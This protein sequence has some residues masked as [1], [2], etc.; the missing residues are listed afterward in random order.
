M[1]PFGMVTEV[2]EVLL[3]A[4]LPIDF[5]TLSASKVTEVSALESWNAVSP[6]VMTPSGMV[7]EVSEVFLNAP[8]PIEV[9]LFGMVI[10]VSAVLKN[11]L[12]PIEVTLFGIVIEVSEV[13]PKNA[14]LPIEVTLLVITA[15]PAQF[16]LPVT[17][18]SVI[19]NE[20]P[21]LQFT[22]LISEA[23]TIVRPFH[24]VPSPKPV[25]A[26]PMFATASVP[27]LRKASVPTVV[28]ALP[29]K[30]TEV[31]AVALSNAY[32]P[33]EVTL[34]GMIIEVRALAL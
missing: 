5:S 29:S 17:T 22:E 21:A 24:V 13:V 7:I 14:R 9:T 28:C 34:F 23:R 16:V 10:E 3:N 12:V 6:I 27:T 2:S 30:V 15:S 20:P 8:L 18:L 4:A 33:I 26:K 31:S 32:S 11:A 1:T 19:V 25:A